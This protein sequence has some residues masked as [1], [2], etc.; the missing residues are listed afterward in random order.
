MLDVAG[1][2]VGS[3][4]MLNGCYGHMHAATSNSRGI[5]DDACTN[6]NRDSFQYQIDNGVGLVA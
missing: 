2:V 1:V 5:I 3:M 6:Q 4:Y